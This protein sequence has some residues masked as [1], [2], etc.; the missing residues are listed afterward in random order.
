VSGEGAMGDGCA[1][2]IRQ[3]RQ[4]MR[5]QCVVLRDTTYERVR[6]MALS[7]PSHDAFRPGTNVYFVCEPS[8]AQVDATPT[9]SATTSASK[10][11][12]RR[13]GG[14]KQDGEG[15]VHQAPRSL[16]ILKRG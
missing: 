2:E 7:E 5:A 12:A 16:R 15:S 3:K 11:K 13:C 6:G 8:T 9:T 14:G 10:V 1:P 4:E